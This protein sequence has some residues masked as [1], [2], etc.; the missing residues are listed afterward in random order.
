MFIVFKKRDTFETTQLTGVKAI[1]FDGT[2]Y[3]VT[4]SDNTTAT[5]GFAY[6]I[7]WSF[8]A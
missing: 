8:N 5:F 7:M 2:T 4:K 1:A 3:T 6:W